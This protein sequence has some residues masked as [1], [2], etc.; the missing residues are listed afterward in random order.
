MITAISA[1]SARAAILG[2]ALA[3]CLNAATAQTPPASAGPEPS[4]EVLAMAREIIELK[5]S[6]K[7]YGPIF[8]GI[9]EKTKFTFMQ[10]NPMLQ[11]DLNEVAI[12]LRNEFQPRLEALKVELARIYAKRFS[13]QEIK[14]T[15]AFYK[16]PLGSKVLALE[17]QVFEQS[18]A[19]ASDWAEKLADEVMAKMRTEMRKR[20]HEL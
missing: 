14:Q 18:M 3:G 11:K 9:I 8:I 4:A 15:L 16:S 10:T 6:S 7:L 20:G 19:H 5:G 13:E 1:A 17:P 12:L 2:L